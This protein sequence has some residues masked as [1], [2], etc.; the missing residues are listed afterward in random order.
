MRI[1]VNDVISGGVLGYLGPFQF[2]IGNKA[3]FQV[4]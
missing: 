1:F 4:F 2:F 3:T